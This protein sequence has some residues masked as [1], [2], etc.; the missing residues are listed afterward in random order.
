M[1]LDIVAPAN[2]PVATTTLTTV[3]KTLGNQEE[4]SRDKLLSAVKKATGYSDSRVRIAEEVCDYVMKKVAGPSITTG[5]INALVEGYLLAKYEKSKNDVYKNILNKYIANKRRKQDELMQ[6]VSH[7]KDVILGAGSI[8]DLRK[9]S[10]NQTQIAAARYLLRN[11]ETGEITETIPQ[12]FDRVASHVV[13]GSIMYDEEIYSKEELSKEKYTKRVKDIDG[14]V[15]RI[16]TNKLGDFQFKI[17]LEKY[18]EL[19]KHMKYTLKKTCE[20]IDKK[21]IDKYNHLYKQYYDF[22]Y[23]G[24]FE[25]N[26]PTLLNMGTPSGAGSACFTI[27]VD[28]DMESICKADHDASF[29]FKCAGGFGTNVS[30]IRPA[31]SPVGNTF[32]AAT[33]PINLVLEKINHTTDIVKAGGKRRGANM[34]IME[35]WHPQ[36]LEFIDYKLKPGKLENFNISVMFDS[37]FWK[38]YES[39]DNIH[40]IFGNKIYDQINAVELMKKIA[41]NAWKSAEPGVLFADNA[42]RKNPLRDVWGDIKITN[43]C[44]SATTKLHTNKGMI[45][46]ESLYENNT[47][48]E[49]A[50]DAVMH[51]SFKRYSKANETQMLQKP[52]SKVFK[53]ADDADLLRIETE[54]GYELDCTPYHPMVLANG[55]MKDASDLRTGDE[56]LL[57]SSKGIFGNEGTSDIGALLGFAQN[58]MELIT[59]EDKF[60]DVVF[61]KYTNLNKFDNIYHRLNKQFI[62]NIYGEPMP[63]N[64]IL[65]AA[66]F[67]HN[68]VPDVIWK[69]TEQCVKSYLKLLFSTS[70]VCIVERELIRYHNGDRRFLQNL[71]ILL[72]NFGIKST[73]RGNNPYYLTVYGKSFKPFM[74]KI[75]LTTSSKIRNIDVPRDSTGEIKYLTKVTSVTKLPGKHKVYDA[76]EYD[77]HKLIFNGI[78]TGN[79]SEQYMYH[80]ESCTLGSINLAKLID[81]DKFNW[82]EYRKTIWISTQFL[83]DVLEVNQYPTEDIK[84]NS[85]ITKRIG[86]GIMGL[87]DMLFK[88]RIPYNSEQGYDMMNE[89]SKWLFTESVNWS[90]SLAEQRGPCDAYNMLI[91]SGK[92]P[93]DVI[94]RVYP[95]LRTDYPFSKDLE[96]Y[97]VRNMWTTTIAPTGTISMIADCSNGLEPIYALVYKKTVQT[98]DHYYLNKE[99]ENALIQEGLYSDD[100]IKKVEQNYGSV[101]GLPEIPDWMQK[102]FVTA[103]DLHW[104]DHVVAQAIWQTWI[105]NSISK[106]INMPNNVTPEDIEYAYVLSHELG[107]KGVS[108]YRDG[109]RHLQVLHTDTSVKTKEGEIGAKSDKEITLIKKQLAPSAATI[110]YI[111]KNVKNKDILDKFM[112]YIDNDNQQVYIQ[113]NERCEKCSEG[114]YVNQ[115]G[116]KSCITCGFSVSCSVG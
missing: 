49:V 99:F 108:V 48:I 77:T 29:I 28:D 30:Y 24:I 102:V 88:M 34:G 79:C 33:G 80:G 45:D 103:M 61:Q 56:L 18:N 115:G 116:C 25:P 1:T 5:Y 43:P 112:K 105:D 110:D 91:E 9:F 106:T 90:V 41:D 21:L 31:G 95:E 59:P 55:T 35:Y 92:Q 52:A 100:I 14:K 71:Q 16:R 3:I 47:E 68:V 111:M 10:F 104:T 82:A 86:L 74:Y 94:D 89:L 87:A 17:I 19:I 37:A 23:Q 69:G 109:S 39:N 76:E 97:G 7:L 64:F 60:L 44:V 67:T 85:N 58:H 27:K 32:N 51:K 36:I 101:Q 22:M 11:V 46:V 54:D 62:P 12:W 66:K 72:I 65:D 75:G 42:N 53:T 84:T 83:N 38:R 57:Q 78:I 50:V 2:V 40:T 96:R 70:A 15:V 6:K 113:A 98:G 93:S 63:L 20:I 114:V 73:I 26:T 8:R 13:L 81:G 4:F 107:L